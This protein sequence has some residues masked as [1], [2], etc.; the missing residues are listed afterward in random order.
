MLYA[1]EAA[2]LAVSVAVSEP[3]YEETY[4]KAQ[5]VE[6]CVQMGEEYAVCPELLMAIIEHESSGQK[7]ARNGPCVGLMQLNE[8]YH[9]IGEDLTD[10]ETNIRIGAAYIAELAEEYGDIGL[11]LMKY[12]GEKNAKQKAEKG[13]L[14]DYAAGILERSEE[15]ERAHGK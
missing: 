10:P 8:K 3:V 5:Y 11:V 7:D 6:T 15:L 12:H 4:I 1:V 2:I 13:I 9:G 14:S